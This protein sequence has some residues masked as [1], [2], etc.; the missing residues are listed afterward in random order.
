[1]AQLIPSVF[2]TS[3]EDSPFKEPEEYGYSDDPIAAQ[4]ML[5]TYRPGMDVGAPDLGFFGLFKKGGEA[6]ATATVGAAA[7]TAG[8]AAGTGAAAAGGAAA[9]QAAGGIGSGWG[10]AIDGAVALTTAAI[11]TGFAVGQANKQRVHEEKM[12]EGEQKL[13][14]QQAELAALQAGQGGGSWLPWIIGGVVVLGAVGGG[15]YWHTR[16]DGKKK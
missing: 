13:I 12:L 10:M 5:T 1:M 16:N 2:V 15:A 14:D 9:G 11:G 3:G 7:E 4:T 8:G 6:A